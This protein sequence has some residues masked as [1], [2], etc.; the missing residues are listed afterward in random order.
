MKPSDGPMPTDS[1]A[2]T[3]TPDLEALAK[4]ER[5]HRPLSEGELESIRA[6][7]FAAAHAASAVKAEDIKVLDMHE[8]V[9]YTDYLVVCTGRNVRQTRRIVEEIGFR[10]KNDRGLSPRGVE[11]GAG[12]EWILMDYLDFIV[13]V[14]TPEAREF[15][16]LDV[17]WKQA[18][19]EAVE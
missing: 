3:S 18:P 4:R 16:R 10:L 5:P 2:P 17:L 11:G 8:V 14:F 19:V 9:T 1:P 6:A 15:Y 7:A 13:H 12:G